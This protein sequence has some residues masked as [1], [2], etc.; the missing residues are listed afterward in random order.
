MERGRGEGEQENVIGGEGWY[1]IIA[2]EK[3]IDDKIKLL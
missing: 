2:T 1:H 3:T